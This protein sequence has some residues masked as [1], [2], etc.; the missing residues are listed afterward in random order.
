MIG[1]IPLNIEKK[2]NSWYNI[3]GKLQVLDTGNLPRRIRFYSSLA[4]T[5]MLEKGIV[6]SKLKDSYIVMICPFD[7]YG[8]GR[9]IYTFTN[10]CKQDLNLEMGDGTTK[11]VLNA[12]GTMD[13][14]SDKLKAFL[15]YVA[16]KNVDDEY[17][18]KLDEAVHKARA[19]K[20]WRREY[21]TLMMRDLENQEIG[22]EKGRSIRDR[23]KIEEMLKRG[24]EPQEI[25]DFCNYPLELILEV[26]KNLLVLQ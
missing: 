22:L 12:V 9:H 10:R 7:Q 6:Y 5:Q 19:N 8:E 17:V 1:N 16:G 26:Q 23:E 24:K 3:K 14:V 18:K 13:D 25:A 15:D 11:I 21:M 20:E 4:D 2:S